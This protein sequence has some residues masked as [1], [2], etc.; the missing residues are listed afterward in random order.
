MLLEM[1]EGTVDKVTIVNGSIVIQKM[2]VVEGFE[3]V[4]RDSSMILDGDA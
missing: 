2:A 1:E 4:F 3:E